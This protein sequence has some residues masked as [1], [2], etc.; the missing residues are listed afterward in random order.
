MTEHGN[1][2]LAGR[3][4]RTKVGK[5]TS[6]ESHTTLQMY[7]IVQDTESVG[8]ELHTTTPAEVLRITLKRQTKSALC[9]A[10]ALPCLVTSPFRRR[11][12]ARP[13]C[14]NRSPHPVTWNG[15][16]SVKADE[17]QQRCRHLGEVKKADTRL[18]LAGLELR[19]CS[20][21]YLQTI[22][23]LSERVLWH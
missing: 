21:V 6:V 23:I 19:E 5:T 20:L 2:T 17:Q 22:I 3:S 9:V 1:P 12:G 14:P 16:G 10:K 11:C 18:V 13:I 15:R 7:T 8:E 4:T